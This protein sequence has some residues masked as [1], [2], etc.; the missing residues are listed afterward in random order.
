MGSPVKT[1]VTGDISGS[2]MYRVAAARHGSGSLEWL[3]LLLTLLYSL[4]FL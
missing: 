4:P 1:R 3:C 2:G